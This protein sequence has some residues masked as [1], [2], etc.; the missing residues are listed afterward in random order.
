MRAALLAASWIA[1]ATT[2]SRTGYTEGWPAAIRP[3][4]SLYMAVWALSRNAV[5]E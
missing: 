5:R 3:S 4:A 1:E 2:R